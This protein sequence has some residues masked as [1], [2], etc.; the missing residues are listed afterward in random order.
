MSP[1][2]V[3]PL[4]RLAPPVSSRGRCW[5]QVVWRT[6]MRPSSVALRSPRRLRPR[7]QPIRQTPTPTSLTISPMSFGER[8]RWLT[9]AILR[10][11][12]RKSRR[13]KRLTWLTAARRSRRLATPQL[14][15]PLSA[16]QLIAPPFFLPA[17]LR[18]LLMRMRR[19]PLAST[20]SAPSTV[21]RLPITIRHWMRSRP[22]AA[23]LAILLCFMQ[24]A[25]VT[26]VMRLAAWP[27]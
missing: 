10:P 17:M 6:P 7:H 11:S 27:H 14:S 12:Q 25:L 18:I 22:P 3:S 5:L 8:R 1:R 2:A 15:A 4:L 16:H 26:P 19:P 23:L 13:S 9:H 24:R 21:I 20:C